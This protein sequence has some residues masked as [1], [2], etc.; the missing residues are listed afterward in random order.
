MSRIA[1]V[2]AVIPCRDHAAE[3]NAALAA[4]ARVDTRGLSLR[5]VVVDDAS[6]PPLAI[7][8]PTHPLEVRR[9][10]LAEQRGG[11]GAFNAGIRAAMESPRTPDAVWLLDSDAAATP[12]ALLPL[13]AAL[14]DDAKAIAAGSALRDPVSGHLYEAGGRVGRWSGTATPCTPTT[15]RVVDYAAACSLLIRADA[16]R[17]AGLFPEV[18]LSHD[19]IAWCLEA[20]RRLGG[21]VVAVPQSIVDHPWQRV[22]VAGRYYASRN[23]WPALAHR[24][25][26]ARAGRAAVESLLAMG[27]SIEF[28]PEVGSLHVQGW[29]DAAASAWDRRS[30]RPSP[31]APASRSLEET[32]ATLEA[33]EADRSG[34]TVHPHLRPLAQR[35]G[36]ESANAERRGRSHARTTVGDLLAFARRLIV[37]PKEGIVIAPAAWPFA[38]ARR[39]TAWHPSNGRIV[40]TTPNSRRG[41]LPALRVMLRGW[42]HLAQL[43]VRPAKGPG[44]PPLVSASDPP[45]AAAP[46]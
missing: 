45:A 43:V 35:L 29:R 36:L 39:R 21:H 32:V 17:H 1:S 31:A 19:D 33:S 46:R 16:L 41:L 30:P 3:A 7:D 23:C 6:D 40:V 8:D 42:P 15:R 4:L 10:R 22:H 34:C 27:S 37:G 2:V 18:F 5:A 11:S 12:G 25:I 13:V 44:L 20:S 9:V 14:D 28:G 26:L 24:G 38:W